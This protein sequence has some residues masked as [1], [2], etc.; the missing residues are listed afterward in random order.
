MA[1]DITAGWMIAPLELAAQN[2]NNDREQSIIQFLGTKSIASEIPYNGT[3]LIY[4]VRQMSAPTGI[5]AIK[6]SSSVAMLRYLRQVKRP[7]EAS[8][9]REQRLVGSFVGGFQAC[10][11]R[12]E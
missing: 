8:E 11:Q 1:G 2:S 6:A 4:T 3:H 9:R 10:Q 12:V 5:Q 7:L